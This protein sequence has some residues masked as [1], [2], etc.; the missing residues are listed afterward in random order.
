MP[1][2][3]EADIAEE[4]NCTVPSYR[5]AVIGEVRGGILACE[6]AKLVAVADAKFADPLKCTDN[7][8]N[9]IEARLP[10]KTK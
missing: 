10:K 1:Y 9:M 6:N 7:L 3:D 8:T 5:E 4:M 2:D